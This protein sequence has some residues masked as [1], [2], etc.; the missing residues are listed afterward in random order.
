MGAA[1]LSAIVTQVVGP[2]IMNIVR[3]HFAATGELPTDA[4]VIAKLNLDAD[5]TIARGEA[6]VAQG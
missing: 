6:F 5:A 4:E 2:E 1:L 3:A